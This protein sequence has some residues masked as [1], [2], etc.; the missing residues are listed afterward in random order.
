MPTTP[1]DG[2][3]LSQ[4][5]R[6]NDLRET[7]LVPLVRPSEPLPEDQN[8]VIPA[9]RLA[10]I[11]GTTP[12]TVPPAPTYTLY[13]APGTHTDG[14]MHQAATTAAL[15]VKA[16]LASPTFSGVPTAP[17]P[18]LAWDAFGQLVTQGFLQRTYF[19]GPAFVAHK[20]DGTL[21]ATLTTLR[22]ACDWTGTGRVIVTRPVLGTNQ[23]VLLYPGLVLDLQHH[24][25]NLDG[26]DLH[27]YDGAQ[28]INNAL[29]YNG[30]I[31]VRGGLASGAPSIQGGTLAAQIFAQAGA[32]EAL[33]LDGV[34][35][36]YFGQGQATPAT[37]GAFT[38]TLRNGSAFVAYAPDAAT[39][40]VVEPVTRF[41]YAQNQFGTHP[42]FASQQQLNE[43]L[44]SGTTTPATESVTITNVQAS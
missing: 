35:V 10:E 5:N 9:G 24:P 25:L 26:G 42:A 37:I 44:L 6:V 17:T 11:L 8:A 15:A 30:R 32:S 27:L 19:D 36:Q 40:L 3:P 39:T 38:I 12:G 34:Q 1:L 33:I 18:L 21:N 14:P 23:N 20:A 7:D 29:I 13:G 41:P 16:P 2:R 4:T 31:F 43:Y 22:A 28:V